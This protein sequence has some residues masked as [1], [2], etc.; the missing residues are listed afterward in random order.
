MRKSTLPLALTAAGLAV[1]AA[2]P[3]AQADHGRG[4]TDQATRARVAE[5]AQQ[6]VDAGNP[7]VVVRYDDGRAPVEIAKQAPWTAKDHRLAADDEVRVGS[8]TKTVVATLVLQL[9]GEGRV[10]LDDPVEK[11]LPGLVPGGSGIT[12]RM[13]LNHTSGLADYVDDQGVVDSVFGKSTKKWTS[14]E[15]LAAGTA[16]PPTSAPGT[17]WKYSNTNYVALGMVLEKATGRCLADLVDQ[18]IVRPLR[19]KHTYLAADATWRGRHATGYEPDAAHLKALLP[20]EAPEGLAFVGPEHD[21]HV[22]VSGIDP[23]WG[24]A[25]GA[26]VSTAGEWGRF[27]TALLSGELLAPAQ[28]AQL[29]TV[30]PI[31]PEAPEGAGYGLGI[32][33]IPTPCG[34]VWGHVGGIPGYLSK[35]YTDDTGT[36][37]VAVVTMT[38]YG[39]TEPKADAANK[40]LETAAVCAMFD[41][42]V[43]QS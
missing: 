7:G 11:W 33:R 25:A 41:K 36:R 34:V 14:R 28:L 3:A 4:P 27:Q 19:L 20:P 38:Y 35:T 37:S 22:D 5:L 39:E 31:G 6:A 32:A 23:G 40:A 42:P 21:E 15:L 10:G 13:L 24:W 1:I 12:L 43:P 8:N 9:V 17:T 30:V 26:V 18:R 2:L 29:R 16:L